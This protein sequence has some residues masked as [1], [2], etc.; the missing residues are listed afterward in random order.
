MIVPVT[1]LS[2]NFRPLDL[3]AAFTADTRKGLYA[4]DKATK[5]TLPFVKFGRVVASG[6]PF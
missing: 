3:S 5:D 4:S 6:V 1:A 2:G